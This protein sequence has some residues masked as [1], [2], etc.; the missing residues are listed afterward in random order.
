MDYA[1]SVQV[2]VEL[3]RQLSLISA[4]LGGLSLLIV[5]QLFRFPNQKKWIAWITGCFLVTASSLI[6]S[7]YLSVLYLT[8]YEYEISY[9]TRRLP[10][11][12]N[13]AL[14][15][16][17]LFS[18]GFQAFIVGMGLVGWLRSRRIGILSLILTI[19][20]EI[21]MAG[22]IYWFNET[23]LFWKMLTQ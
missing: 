23:T 19:V 4:L 7:S 21:I 16:V 11:F 17:F 3:V 12:R 5:L 8:G 22:A 15:V 10:E 9:S 18:F 20:I 1:K 14:I 2:A 6:V 13:T